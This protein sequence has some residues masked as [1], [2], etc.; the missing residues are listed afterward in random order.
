MAVVK[1]LVKAGAEQVLKRLPIEQA[2]T[3]VKH[4]NFPTGS[5]QHTFV[6]MGGIHPMDGPGLINSIK[7]GEAQDLGQYINHAVQGE[8]GALNEIGHIADNGTN[9]LIQ[10]TGKAQNAQAAMEPKLAEPANIYPTKYD[11]SDDQAGFDTVHGNLSKWLKEERVRVGGDIKKIDRS[12]FAPEGI[13]IG[14]E[15]RT[16]SGITKHLEKGERIKLN[17]LGAVEA[18]LKQMNP[19]NVAGLRAHAEEGNRAWQQSAKEYEEAFGHLPLKDRPEFKPQGVHPDLTFDEFKSYIRAGARRADELTA[20]YAKKFGLDLDKEHM[21]AIGNKATDDARSQFPGSESYNRRMGKIDSFYRIVMEELGLPG[22]GD[23]AKAAEITG[24]GPRATARRLQY[25]QSGWWK[26]YTDWAATDGASLDDMSQWNPGDILTDSD[27]LKLQRIFGQKGKFNKKGPFR[28]PSPRQLE[29]AQQIVAERQIA[30]A[31]EKAGLLET[32]DE[33]AL[34]EKLLKRIDLDEKILKAKR[35]T[36]EGQLDELRLKHPKDRTERLLQRS[37][38]NTLESRI[39]QSK[40]GINKP[41]LLKFDKKGNLIPPKELVEISP[42]VAVGPNYK[43]GQDKALDAVLKKLAK[44]P[45]SLDSSGM[46]TRM[47]ISDRN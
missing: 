7:K 34:V 25:E 3:I 21:A 5:P 10:D 26:S 16:I 32:P 9:D 4:F 37:E 24:T 40:R 15:E 47:N 13:Y 2:D 27:K 43:P 29:M 18:R 46:G 42:G 23:A 1:Q 22:A 14:G 6:T 11:V 38:A 35:S 33:I 39:S 8:Q 41:K 31:A 19:D 44:D 45:S 30:N 20:E 12:K 36:P 17:K 28:K